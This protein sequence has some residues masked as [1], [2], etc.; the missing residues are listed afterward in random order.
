[1]ID[2]AGGLQLLRGRD[3]AI[4]HEIGLGHLQDLAAKGLRC[5][6]APTAEIGAEGQR[7]QLLDGAIVAG[8]GVHRQTAAVSVKEPGVRRQITAA[9][10]KEPGVRPR[11]TLTA[12]TQEGW[13][14]P[15]HTGLAPNAG[16]VQATAPG[17]VRGTGLSERMHHSTR[18]MT[19]GGVHEG[20]P[21]VVEVLLDLICM[22][23]PPRKNGS[24][25]RTGSAAEFLDQAQSEEQDFFDD[26]ADFL[27][28][29]E[30]HANTV[31]VGTG[32]QKPSTNMPL[33]STSQAAEVSKSTKSMVRSDGKREV[34]ESVPTSLRLARRQTEDGMNIPR[35]QVQTKRVSVYPAAKPSQEASSIASGTQADAPANSL[36]RDKA[37]TVAG[38]PQ[39]D[40]S[41]VDKSA[42][43]DASANGLQQDKSSTFTGGP[44]LDDFFFLN[45]DGLTDLLDQIA[46]DTSLQPQPQEQIVR[47]NQST[48]LET[49][50][51]SQEDINQD[52]PSTLPEV[53][54]GLQR[55][56]TAA[57]QTC[58]NRHV[59]CDGRKPICQRCADEGCECLYT[60]SRRGKRRAWKDNA[61]G[62]DDTFV[63]SWPPPPIQRSTTRPWSNSG[64][65]SYG[66]LGFGILQPGLTDSTHSPY[67]PAFPQPTAVSAY[68]S[69]GPPRAEP[70]PVGTYASYGPPRTEPT[71]DS[72][73]APYGPSRPEPIQDE[74]LFS[75]Q[76]ASPGVVPT[77]HY[78]TTIQECEQAAQLLSGETLLSLDIEWKPGPASNFAG[79]NLS[80]IQMASRD[81]VLV[82]HL[83]LIPTMPP[84]HSGA[85]PE[86]MARTLKN[87]IEN[88]SIMKVGNAIKGD[89]TRVAKWSG[90]DLSHTNVVDTI[91][92]AKDLVT[93]LPN[94]QLATMVSHFLKKRLPKDAVRT[95]D[96][97]RPLGQE[98][99][100]YA[101]NDAYAS[102]LV[103]QHFQV[104]FA[105]SGFTASV[106][107]RASC[108]P[109][110]KGWIARSSSVRKP[111]TSK[112]VAG[113]VNPFFFA[114]PQSIA[115]GPATPSI[116]PRPAATPI[117]PR[118]ATLRESAAILA[119]RANAAR[120]RQRQL[121]RV[122]TVSSRMSGSNNWG[123]T[124]TV[125]DLRTGSAQVGTWLH[126][127]LKDN[128]T[129]EVQIPDVITIDRVARGCHPIATPPREE[130]GP[131]HERVVA[132]RERFG[133]DFDIEFVVLLRGIDGLMQTQ[134][135]FKRLFKWYREQYRYD[136]CFMVWQPS[137]I[138]TQYANFDFAKSMFEDPML[139]GSWSKLMT[140]DD[141]VKA[142]PGDA[143]VEGKFWELCEDMT[144]SKAGKE[145]GTA[146]HNAGRNSIPPS[147]SLFQWH[148][149]QIGET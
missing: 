8:I 92:L 78:C 56:L 22:S 120:Q 108:R 42:Q 4:K 106:K 59:R 99:I 76:T 35:P 58:R 43:V 41:Q 127:W 65:V 52:N 77:V 69:Y 81:N 111:G 9:T 67:V 147:G 11:H 75:Y 114:R 68:G 113:S 79:E 62:P 51:Q 16:S 20:H 86:V 55:N 3:K 31:S 47:E 5:D 135:H 148:A 143:T 129:P 123:T 110:D 137:G 90:V 91:D 44:Q 121:I 80:V 139:V 116:T 125:E 73:Y 18:A 12:I 144:I 149:G 140:L 39:F 138:P 63:G 109:D 115:A 84:G 15:T 66:S 118:P 141:M 49:R 83:A 130:S 97:S 25:G 82:L 101:A 87:I 46:Q 54:A 131:W 142:T 24:P 133:D 6:A 19:A 122:P 7:L 17:A 72:A 136:F 14:A 29:M 124:H 146:G 105:Q 27:A 89:L 57:C 60:V 128:S 112:Q 95:S 30:K 2:T 71:P 26:D 23:R 40:A 48:L 70:T 45:D 88:G 145:P 38:D 34:V 119:E 32:G 50:P 74:E 103:F 53:Q 28:E 13:N 64:T 107:D 94:R 132:V 98:Q 61:P 100:Q 93:D 1:M 36:Q 85:A 10:V 104:A 21:G 33:T 96:W 126:G 102:L 37:S 117:T 134:T